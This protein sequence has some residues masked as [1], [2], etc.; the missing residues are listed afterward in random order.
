MTLN[1]CIWTHCIDAPNA[2]AGNRLTHLV[3]NGSD[4]KINETEVEFNDKVQYYCFNGMRDIDDLHF[5][6]QNATCLPGNSWTTPT[7]W[8]NCTD[9]RNKEFFFITHFY[10]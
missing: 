10:E 4:Y 7:T 3:Y 6:H 1:E 5:S 2:T 8:K 9:S